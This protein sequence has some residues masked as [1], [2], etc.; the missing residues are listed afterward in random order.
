[1]ETEGGLRE[2]LKKPWWVGPLAAGVA[3]MHP[4]APKPKGSVSTS[5]SYQR[6]NSSGL[7]PRYG[8]VVV[9]AACPAGKHLIGGGYILPGT[10]AAASSS[11]PEGNNTW[12]VDFR[13]NGGSG[14]A[15]VYA[16]CDA[17]K[18]QSSEAHP[19]AKIKFNRYMALQTAK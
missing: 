17:K 15:K 1:L 7:L 19:D 2:F 12:R 9:I 4:S 13:S 5:G 10:L 8:S 16:I 11:R 18:L 6:V 14:E 3:F